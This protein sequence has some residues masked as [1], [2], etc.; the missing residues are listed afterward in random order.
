MKLSAIDDC[1]SAA[2]ATGTARE[3]STNVARRWTGYA[4]NGSQL[5]RSRGLPQHTVRGRGREA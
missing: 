2:A 3:G 1:A 4:A 5:S